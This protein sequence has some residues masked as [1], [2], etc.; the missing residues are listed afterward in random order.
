MSQELAE[1]QL[2]RSY[3]LGDL[4]ESEQRQ[5]QERLVT[6]ESQDFFDACLIIEDELVEA[7]A[8]DLISE[9]DRAKLERGLLLN[10]HEYREVEFVRTLDRFIADTVEERDKIRWERGLCKAQTNRYLIHSL[11]TDNWLGLELLLHLKA[12]QSETV[13]D[14]AAFIERDDA[15]LT[16]ALSR[17]NDCKLVQE[18]QGRYSCSP[19]GLEILERIQTLAP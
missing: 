17:L 13:T 5:I 9:P 11:M 4:S 14:L 8:L 3:F 12:V 15:S 6:D 16:V 18:S 19:S 2:I 10:P 1:E 7:Y